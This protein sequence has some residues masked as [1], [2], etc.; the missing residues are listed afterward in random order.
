MRR[1]Q[2]ESAVPGSGA[3]RSSRRT[4]AAF[5]DL[6]DLASGS[7]RISML[8]HGIVICAVT[9]ASRPRSGWEP[10]R[11]WRLSF[12]ESMGPVRPSGQGLSERD[13]WLAK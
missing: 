9:L 12:R 13:G 3:P 7:A 6:D 10:K 4:R 11:V 1:S 2:V 8:A 5:T